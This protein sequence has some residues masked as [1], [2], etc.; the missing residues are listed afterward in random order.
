MYVLKAVI[1]AAV[2]DLQRQEQHGHQVR[3]TQQ[4]LYLGFFHLKLSLHLGQGQ[5]SH[6]RGD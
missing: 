3:F 5:F 1:I 4:L 2:S 6:T